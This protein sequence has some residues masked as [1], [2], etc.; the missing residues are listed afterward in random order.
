MTRN[1]D[2]GGSFV[3]HFDHVKWLILY[4][5][6]TRSVIILSKLAAFEYCALAQYICVCACVCIYTTDLGKQK[7][8]RSKMS[9]ISNVMCRLVWYILIIVIRTGLRPEIGWLAKWYSKSERH[10]SHHHFTCNDAVSTLHSAFQN[11]SHS[12]FCRSVIFGICAARTTIMLHTLFFPFIQ[13]KDLSEKTVEI[14]MFIAIW[15]S[16]SA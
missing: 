4:R 15:E 14:I 6:T 13:R 12:N 2:A 7:S 3:S 9:C 10:P 16:A 5:Q 8:R 11:K 1:S